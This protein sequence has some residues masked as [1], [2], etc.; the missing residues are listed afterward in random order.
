MTDATRAFCDAIAEDYADPFRDVFA[1]QPLEL[2]LLTGL[3]GLL[4]A[5]GEVAGPGCGPGWVTAHLASCGLNAFGLDLS[6]SVTGLARRENPGLRFAQGSMLEPDLPDGSLAGVVSWCS[7]IHTP[8]DDLPALFAGFR[9]ILAP[10]GHLL[11]AF[12]AGEEARRLERPFGH[13]VVLDFLRRR[14]DRMVDL[15]EAAGS[16][17]VLR[18]ERAADEAQGESTPRPS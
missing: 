13:P 8:Q 16:T 18:S 12:Q 4:G 9:R 3:A 2:T 5:G 17:L 14:P 11:L 10:G 1:A 7:S 6:E 15:L